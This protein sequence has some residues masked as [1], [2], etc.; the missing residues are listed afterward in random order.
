MLGEITVDTT[1]IWVIGPDGSVLSGPLIDGIALQSFTILLR[2]LRSMPYTSLA[3][4]PS[5]SLGALAGP[6]GI[7]LLLCG[8]V[9]LLRRR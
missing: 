4:P 3:A 1:A 7:G 5:W 2:R 9:L 8:M 6:I